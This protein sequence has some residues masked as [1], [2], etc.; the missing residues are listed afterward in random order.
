MLE[1][2]PECPVVCSVSRVEHPLEWLGHRDED[3]RFKRLHP[4]DVP[5]R[6]QDARPVYRLNG[7]IY[8]IR[9]T[10]IATCDGLL[11]ADTRTIVTPPETSIDIDSELD[12]QFAET[13]FAAK[14]APTDA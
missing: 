14:G 8:A 12:L 3:G 6:R 11:N 2:F 9:S 13:L 7:A 5:D 10:H 4:G 1:R